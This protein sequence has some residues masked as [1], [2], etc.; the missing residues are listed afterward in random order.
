MALGVLA[1]IG[2]R[3]LKIVRRRSAK[4]L[5]ICMQLKE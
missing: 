5:G 1:G 2:A 4:Q 3:K